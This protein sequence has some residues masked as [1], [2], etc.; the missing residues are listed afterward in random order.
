[1]RLS[2]YLISQKEAIRTNVLLE[3]LGWQCGGGVVVDRSGGLFGLPKG[4]DCEDSYTG[5]VDRANE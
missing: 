1:M 5:N 4:L 2:F 3:K